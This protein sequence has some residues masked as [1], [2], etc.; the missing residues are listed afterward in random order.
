MASAH[1]HR[2]LMHASQRP[3]SSSGAH[4]PETSTARENDLYVPFGRSAPAHLL[5]PRVLIRLHR[6]KTRHPSPPNPRYT[7]SCDDSVYTDL[8][9]P[10]A[11]T[12][13]TSDFH[14]D[15]TSLCLHQWNGRRAIRFAL[16]GLTR[17]PFHAPILTRLKYEIHLA[18][19]ARAN[20]ACAHELRSG[21]SVANHRETYANAFAFQ[22]SS[23][24]AKQA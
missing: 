20:C 19:D 5:R 2:C 7:Q 14:S 8:C 17:R 18:S 21:T 22:T 12:Y 24:S 10:N 23:R 3:F 15:N 16:I 6:P 13:G 4:A 1:A 9:H 11:R